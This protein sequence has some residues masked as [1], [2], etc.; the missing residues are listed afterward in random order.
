MLLSRSHPKSGGAVAA[1]LK[2]GEA[3]L[4]QPWRAPPAAARAANEAVNLRLLGLFA[5]AA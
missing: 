2:Q 3:L 1:L 4:D 5:D